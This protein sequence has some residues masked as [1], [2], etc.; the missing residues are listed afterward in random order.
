[1]RVDK[2][3]YCRVRDHL[4]AHDLDGPGMYI[5]ANSTKRPATPEDCAG[6]IIWVILCAGRSAQSARTIEKK[7]WNAILHGTP[8]VDVFGHKKK[9]AAIERAWLEREKDFETLKLIPADD[10]EQLITWCYSHPFIGDDTQF[11]L[12]KN[13]GANV[14]KP[15]IWLCRLAGIPD[16]PR[17]PLRERFHRCQSLCEELS[18]ATGDRVGVIDTMLWLACNKGILNVGADAGTISFNQNPSQA[19]SIMN[20]IDSRQLA[21]F[22]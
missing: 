19:K 17:K 22:E 8:V 15:D 11:Q 1:M 6:E 4:L 9:A 13:F 18:I 3:L 5:W 21:L 16:K 20:T 10:I 2:E 14:C 7:V 12:A